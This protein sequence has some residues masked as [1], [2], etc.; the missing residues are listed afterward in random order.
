[1]IPEYI[2]HH[3][4]SLKNFSLHF[5]YFSV[6]E[7]PLKARVEHHIK[8]ADTI[9]KHA[10]ATLKG[11]HRR[12]SACLGNIQARGG[13]CLEI[14]ARLQAPFVSGLGSCHPTETGFVLD[15]N[16]GLPYIPASAVKGVLR[17]A[18][19]L[20]IAERHPERVLEIRGGFEIDD[21]EPTMRKYFGD[22]DTSAKDA[23]RG[24][25]V[26]LDAFPAS[27]PAIKQ[28]IM[29]PHF[30]PY[31]KGEAP[32][33]ET[34]SPIPVMFMAVKEGVEFKFRVFALPLAEGAS[35]SREF[36]DDDRKAIVAMFTRACTQLGFGA[37][38][39]IGYGRMSDVRDTSAEMIAAW[40]ESRI[41]EDN[42]R[43]PWRAAL[44]ELEGVTDWGGFRQKGL[45]SDILV[46]HRDK[47]EVGQRVY[48]LAH[49]LRK[50]W[51]SGWE[52]SRDDL[53]AEWLQPAGL[54][55]P[56]AQ[57][58]APAAGNEAGAEL[59]RIKEIKKWA[60]YL[61]EPARLDILSKNGLKTLRDKLK[62]WGCD[63]KDTKPDKRAAWEELMRKMKN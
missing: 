2:R 18:H 38:T 50:K 47:P 48:E 19:A 10:D 27:L 17:M 28:D 7:T 6:W 53:I 21:R 63:V 1:M 40:E 11:L 42:R 57:E 60:D 34:D 35:V 37:K 3:E 32:P 12:Q 14:T 5:D 58:A 16:S 31:Y 4:S 33:R 22:T 39:S 20:D 62:G 46:V 56:P 45:E 59:E 24:Q 36:S 43:H 61:A 13:M 55:W 23:V 44:R 30:G 51:K 15:R 52:Q 9:L 49:E 26:F 25:L 8:A 41:E 29:N 54:S